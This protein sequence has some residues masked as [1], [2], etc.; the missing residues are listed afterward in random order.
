MVWHRVVESQTSLRGMVFG[1]EIA[2]EQ[3]FEINGTTRVENVMTRN[4]YEAYTLDNTIGLQ[5]IRC[6]EH[7]NV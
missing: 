1:W 3:E 7:L 2:D 5:I 4:G 6:I